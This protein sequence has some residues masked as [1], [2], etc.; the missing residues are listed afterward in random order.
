V[1][2]AGDSGEL[3]FGD[4][5]KGRQRWLDGGIGRRERRFRSRLEGVIEE[6]AFDGWRAGTGWE[7]KA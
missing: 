7:W 6:V 2:V 4:G 3:R 5:G 1:C